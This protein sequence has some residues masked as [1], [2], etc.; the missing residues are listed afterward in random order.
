MVSAVVFQSATLILPRVASWSNNNF[1]IQRFSPS[2]FVN[3]SKKLDAS[4][5]EVGRLLSGF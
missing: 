1:C 2:P 3:I 5:F 4:F